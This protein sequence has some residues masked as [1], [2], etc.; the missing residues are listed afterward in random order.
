[1][2]TDGYLWLRRRPT[3]ALDSSET[4]AGK[5]KPIQALIASL[6]LFDAGEPLD[7][8]AALECVAHGL[9]LEAQRTTQGQVGWHSHQWKNGSP[10]KVDPVRQTPLTRLLLY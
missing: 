1:M 2:T 7:R 9:L 8:V 6:N 10:T 4:P 5:V 3:W